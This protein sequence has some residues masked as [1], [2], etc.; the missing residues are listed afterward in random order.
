MADETGA[1][2][3]AEGIADEITTREW[4]DDRVSQPAPPPGDLP[5][6]PPPPPAPGLWARLMRAIRGG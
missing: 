6:N 3:D 4:L 2:R 1:G 5:D